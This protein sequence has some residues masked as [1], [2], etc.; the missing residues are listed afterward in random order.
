[1]RPVTVQFLKNPDIIHWG[2]EASF[3]GEDEYGKWMAAPAG[4]KRWKGSEAFD[5]TRSNAVFCA[6]HEGWWHLHYNGPNTA[7]YTLFVDIN[8]PPRWIGDDR[9]EMIDLDLDV[10]MTHDG[11]IVVEDEDEFELHQL[12]YGYS[13]EMIRGALEATRWVTDALADRK[14]PFFEVAESWLRKI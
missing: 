13:Q 11:E 8:T 7:N 12:S 10:G 1:M 2:F 5:A 14:E 4:T 3:L 6:P 9:Y